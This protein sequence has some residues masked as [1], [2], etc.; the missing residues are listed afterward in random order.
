VLEEHRGDAEPVW[1]VDARE[2]EVAHDHV[3]VPERAARSTAARIAVERYFATA[4]GSGESTFA[5]SSAKKRALRF[6]AVANGTR[7]RS[8]QYSSVARSPRR[9]PPCRR[10]G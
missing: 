2:E 5:A 8:W 7:T 6:G 10:R 9:A 3:H 4:Y 1:D